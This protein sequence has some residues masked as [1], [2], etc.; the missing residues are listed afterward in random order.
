MRFLCSQ[1]PIVLNIL[2]LLPSERKKQLFKSLSGKTVEICPGSG[3]NF[4]Y[5]PATL[6][7]Y[8]GF[9]HN[10]EVA[11]LFDRTVASLSV[12]P[13]VLDM[14]SDGSMVRQLKTLSANSIHNIVATQALSSMDDTESKQTLDQILRV[15]KPGG[16][17]YFV[18]TTLNPSYSLP[19]LIRV[20]FNPLTKFFFGSSKTTSVA[21]HI[22]NTGFEKVYM[23]EWPN[24]VDS[25]D[26]R[27]GVLLVED[28]RAKGDETCLLSSLHSS[29][30]V[31]AGICVK[32]KN[33]VK[34][35]QSNFKATMAVRFT[36]V[37]EKPKQKAA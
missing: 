30:A 13:S 6:V 14:R 29:T 7:D 33:D 21:H 8:T 23:E 5:F 20:V 36:P 16:K 26:P 10:D 4:R 1:H 17:L 2:L 15:L 24:R 22:Y 31:V 9:H 37:W 11:L 18:E 34:Q 12:C 3:N 35:R 25:Q 19:K 32:N 28:N 27:K